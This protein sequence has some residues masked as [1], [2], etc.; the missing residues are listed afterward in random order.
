MVAGLAAWGLVVLRLALIQL[1]HSPELARCAERQH[2]VRVRLAPERGTIYDRNLVPLTDNLTVRSA[3]AHPSEIESPRAV[4][5]ALARVLGG[6]YETYLSRLREERDFVWIERQ[7]PP[8]K[9]SELAELNLPGIGFL[10]ENKRVYPYGRRACHVLGT[11]DVDGRGIAGIEREADDILTGSGAWVQYCLDSAGLRTPTPASTEIIPR[12]GASVVLTIDLELQSI[13]EV[14]LERAVREHRARHGIVIIQDPWTGEILAMAN[15]P[16]FDPNCP[17]RYSVDS[18]KNR[19]ITDQFEPGSTFKLVT[20][21][22]ALSTGAADLSSVYFAGRGKCSFGRFTIHDAEEHGWLDFEHAFSRSSNVCFAKIARQV[23]EVPLYSFA[24]EFGFGSLT[25]IELPGEVRG[26]LREPSEWSSR[27]LETIAVG[28]EVAVT[29]LQLV[30]AYSAVANGGYLMQPIVV[31][32]VLGSDGSV[33]EEARPTPV[34]RVI[35][36]DVAATMRR[37]MFEVT[38]EGTG[39]RARVD[40][41]PVAGKTGTAQKAVPGMRGFARGRYVSSF[42][43]MAPADEPRLVCLVVIDEPEG[44]GLGGEVAAPAFSRIVERVARGPEYER[45]AIHE[46]GVP[47][48]GGRSGDAQHGGSAFAAAPGWAGEFF[49]ASNRVA[50]TAGLGRDGPTPALAGVA[51]DA[52]LVVACR[53]SCDDASVPDLRGMSIRRAR[54]MAAELGLVLEVAGSGVVRNQA[55]RPGVPAR[56]GERVVVNCSPH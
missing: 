40:G 25:G 28:Q 41:L 11:T 38:E 3:C 37:L 42:V 48:G 15:W 34:R 50:R 55:P 47:G 54:R 36:S 21:C 23:G 30:G 10:K 24:R 4:A 44:R 18:Q 9:A 43:G 26:M 2:I 12:E 56:P 53:P 8:S 5:R 27:S 17:A 20:A 7:L 22:A 13:A 6:G 46:P 31:K 19:A 29:A 14:E 16:T 35:D 51:P 52:G 49:P 1:V 33:I 32:A 45:L 39:R